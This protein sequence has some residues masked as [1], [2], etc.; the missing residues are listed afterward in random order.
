MESI[1]DEEGNVIDAQKV[2]DDDDD[3]EEE[4]EEEEWRGCVDDDWWN[5]LEIS[6]NGIDEEEEEVCRL[7]IQ[8]GKIQRSWLDAKMERDMAFNYWQL[9]RK[10]EKIWFQEL[11]KIKQK[12][13]LAI[14]KLEK[15]HK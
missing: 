3:D 10:R 8:W 9:K 11:V 14:Q 6:Q 13:R 5:N 4:E 15:S 7:E 2:E 12:L 1:V